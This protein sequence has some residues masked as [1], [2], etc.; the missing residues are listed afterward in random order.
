MIHTSKQLK[1]KVRNLSKGKSD[2]A[3]GLIRNFIMERFLERVSLSN[4]KNNIILKGGML[5]ASLVGLNI[6][7]TMDIDTTVKALPLNEEDARKIIEEICNIE[8]DDGVSFQITSSKKIMEDFDY[9]GIRMMLEAKLDRMKQ[10]F[11]I[12]ISTDD[13]ITPRAI[14]YEYKLMFE[15]RKISMLTYNVETLLA[16]KMQTVLA[17]GLANTRMRDFYDIY[18]I[19]NLKNV[20]INTE[21]L[22]KAFEVT[23]EKRLTKFTDKEIYDILNKIKTDPEFIKMWESF[24][25]ANYFVKDLSWKTIVSFDAEHIKE[26]CNIEYEQDNEYAESFFHEPT[27]EMLAEFKHDEPEQ[28]SFIMTEGCRSDEFEDATEK[29]NLQEDKNL[30]EEEKKPNNESEEEDYGPSL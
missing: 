24:K 20:G 4:Y 10:P 22:Q 5:V 28:D 14:D 27:E 29:E 30:P 18:E 21:V 11:K 7:S 23:C 6:R 12:D 26:I 16:E 1:D 3:Q 9:P 19:M 2:V 17:R 8:V 13:A 25:N 15:D